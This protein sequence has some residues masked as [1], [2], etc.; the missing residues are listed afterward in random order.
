MRIQMKTVGVAHL[1]TLMD[2]F[3]SFKV[4]QKVVK[5][6]IDDYRKTFERF[7]NDSSNSTDYQTVKNEVAKFF[8]KIPDTSPAVFN[9]PYGT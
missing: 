9:R 7:L 8:K 3:I 4:S 2:E 5:R 1:S 6:T